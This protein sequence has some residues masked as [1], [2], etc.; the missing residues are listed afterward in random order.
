[1]PNNT[2]IVIYP[3]LQINYTPGKLVI[4]VYIQ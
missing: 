2:N 3:N 4:I 1:V